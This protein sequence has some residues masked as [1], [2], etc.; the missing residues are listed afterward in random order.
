MLKPNKETAFEKTEKMLYNYHN[1]RRAIEK[2]L[3]EIKYLESEGLDGRSKSIV[4]LSGNQQIDTDTEIE[5]VEE[6]IQVIEASNERL[7][8]HINLIVA[9]LAKVKD[10]PYYTLIRMKYF[11]GK[12]REDIADYFEVDVSTITRNKNRL[13]DVIKIHLFPDDSI[14]ELFD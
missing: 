2:N 7:I 10:D 14:I 11:E 6:K 5:K 3:N 9:A 4:L 8:E 13:I 1:F 12:S